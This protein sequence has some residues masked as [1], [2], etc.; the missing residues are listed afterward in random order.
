LN[1]FNIQSQYDVATRLEKIP[2]ERDKGFDMV[3]VHNTV[4]V[5]L[6]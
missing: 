5:L 4:H 2:T 3:V 6:Q 1:V